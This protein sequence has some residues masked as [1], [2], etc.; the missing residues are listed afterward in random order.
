MKK[1]RPVQKKQSGFTLVE[2]IVVIVILGILAAVAIPKLS[3]SQTNARDAVQQATLGAL[4]S[5]WTIAYTKNKGVAPSL[6]D[7]A[8]QMADP[9]CGTVA[10][11]TAAAAATDTKIACVGVAKTTGSGLAEFG[12]SAT[13]GSPADIGIVTP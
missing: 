2:L 5:A 11:P 13:P 4:K 9:K 7:V 6:A 8:A 3:D 10:D 12:G 1:L